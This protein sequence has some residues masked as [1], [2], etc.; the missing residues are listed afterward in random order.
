MSLKILFPEIVLLHSS[1]GRFDD[2][3]LAL[4]LLALFTG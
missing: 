2:G 4:T 3:L 1:F